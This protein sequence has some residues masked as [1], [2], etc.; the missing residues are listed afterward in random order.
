M[1]VSDLDNEMIG[2]IAPVD[3]FGVEM[4]LLHGL[5]LVAIDLGD[6]EPFVD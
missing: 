1:F 6:R 4:K 5:Q 3:G 2:L